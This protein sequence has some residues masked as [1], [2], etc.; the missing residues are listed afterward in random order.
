[1][2]TIVLRGPITDLDVLTGE[3]RRI[4]GGWVRRDTV[5]LDGV[6]IGFIQVKRANG[7]THAITCSP[8]GG[9]VIGY[10]TRWLVRTHTAN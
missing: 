10:D 7:R 1:M 2:T 6:E 8:H 5:T 3:K 4:W 9:C